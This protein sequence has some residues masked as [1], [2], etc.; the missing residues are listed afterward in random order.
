MIRINLEY[1]VVARD[2]KLVG[3]DFDTLVEGDALY[4]LNLPL[5]YEEAGGQAFVPA[6]DT[7]I[8][9]A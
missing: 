7:F 8:A 4:D 9:H 2:F 6:A 5:L 3:V 1:D